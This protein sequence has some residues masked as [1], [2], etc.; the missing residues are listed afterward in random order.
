MRKIALSSIVYGPRPR[1]QTAAEVI[2]TLHP[3]V[4]G[5]CWSG[6]YSTCRHLQENPSH[7]LWRCKRC[8]CQFSSWHKSALIPGSCVG[9]ERGG[10]PVLLTNVRHVPGLS[11]H[12]DEC[13]LQCRYI[14]K[15]PIC[16]TNNTI[17]LHSNQSNNAYLGWL[18][19]KI[20]SPN[21]WGDG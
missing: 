17:A 10:C 1:R 13:K 2:Q 12:N 7:W 18:S 11:E 21:R 9:R 3:G 19:M 8:Q 14:Y 16:F 15:T 5:L 4:T 20:Q 6:V